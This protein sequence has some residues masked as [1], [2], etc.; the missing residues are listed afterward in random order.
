MRSDHDGGTL[1]ASS[2]QTT[3]GPKTTQRFQNFRPRN[4]NSRTNSTSGSN[5][6]RPSFPHSTPNQFLFDYEAEI[7]FRK[8]KNY[9]LSFSFF[10]IKRKMCSLSF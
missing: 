8:F 4:S 3:T 9:F 1:V 7:S 10:Q 5:F 6:Q 2:P